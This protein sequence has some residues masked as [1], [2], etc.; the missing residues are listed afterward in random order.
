MGIDCEF[1]ASNV[2]DFECVLAL[3]GSTK[4]IDRAKLPFVQQIAGQLR[5]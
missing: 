4:S 1:R 2:A 3:P 5:R